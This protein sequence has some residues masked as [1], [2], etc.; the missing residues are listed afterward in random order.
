MPPTLPPRHPLSSLLPLLL[1]SLLLLL[2]LSSPSPTTAQTTT[3]AALLYNVSLYYADNVTASPPALQSA[4][5]T[6][7]S[8]IFQGAG[9]NGVPFA[10]FGS[11]TSGDLSLRRLSL[12]QA[13]AV[14]ALCMDGSPY[15]Y[16]LRRVSASTS[17]N[18]TKWVVA[19]QGGSLCVDP[20]SCAQRVNSPLGSSAGYQSFYTDLYNV[21]ST[22][23]TQNP[24]FFDW[25]LVFLTYCSG[26]A[27]GGTTTSNR[28]YAALG[29]PYYFAGYNITL[30]AINDLI[31]TQ[32]LAGA[33]DVVV[34]G[35]SSGGIGTIV[36]VDNFAAAL[37]GARVV[38]Y[39]QAGWFTVGA[40]YPEWLVYGGASPTSTLARP[41]YDTALFSVL[42]SVFNIFNYFPP[43]ACLAYFISIG[44]PGNITQ[45]TSMPSLYQ[46][47][48]SPMFILE[49]RFD[50]FQLV[51][52]DVVPLLPSAA[53][54]GYLAYYGGQMVT[55]IAT[56]VASKGSVDGY[57]VPSCLDHTTNPMPGPGTTNEAIRGVQP[58]TVFAAWYAALS[59][60]RLNATSVQAYRVYDPANSLPVPACSVSA[61]FSLPATPS[62]SGDPQ[63]VGLLGQT[64]QVHGIDG[65]VYNLI[66]DRALQL[67]ARFSFIGASPLRACPVMPSTGELCRSCWS[68]SGSYLSQLGLMVQGGGERVKVVAGPAR[69]GF[70]QVEVNGGGVGVGE[71]VGSVRVVS[72]HELVLSVGRWL[73]EVENVD[74][75]V[76]LRSVQL[77]GGDLSGLE[78]HGLLG[79]TWRRVKGGRGRV[80]EIEGEVD[81]YVVAEDS[82]FGSSFVYNRYQ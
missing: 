73:V 60:G 49:N 67:N 3:V 28:T 61:A 75:F 42:Q 25:N 52:L 80:R 29:F 21:L 79:Q 5:Y 47:V 78:S 37:P 64:F 81:D 51:N 30:A 9:A 65:A 18:P 35:V 56:G 34:S 40:T 1:P 71:E 32:G 70:S 15:A 16:Y 58:A 14:G 54:L 26:D 43:P 77:V 69:V 38:G 24:Q 22:N 13:T 48:K 7:A 74:G 12:A 20:I 11:A 6:A 31:A 39:P 44:Q 82:L 50:T 55:S 76:N 59:A 72:S 27:W 23:R 66:S 36:Q 17:A 19:L 33:T 68:H 63:F 2:L 62:V 8:A 57:F 10:T 41:Y 4:L 45:C 46:F 53:T